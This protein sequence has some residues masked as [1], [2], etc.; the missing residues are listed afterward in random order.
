MAQAGKYIVGP[1]ILDN[2]LLRNLGKHGRVGHTVSFIQEKEA[3]G[4]RGYLFNQ[5]HF[6]FKSC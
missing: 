1:A 5:K 3:I 4:R 2:T 6:Q